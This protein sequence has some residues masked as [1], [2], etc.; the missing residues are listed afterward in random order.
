[1]CCKRPAIPDFLRG[2]RIELGWELRVVL[3]A[4]SVRVI[5]FKELSVLDL[6]VD[7]IDL[8]LNC[9]IDRSTTT[10]DQCFPSASSVKTLITT[11]ILDYGLL[12]VQIFL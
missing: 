2:Q 8:L 7:V 6:V 9:W 4:D 12:I 10:R 3:L 5:G 1:M 11:M